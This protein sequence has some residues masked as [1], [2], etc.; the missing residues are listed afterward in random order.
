V[1]CTDYSIPDLTGLL[2]L[3][4]GL[5]YDSFTLNKQGR[6]EM[7]RMEGQFFFSFSLDYGLF[8]SR[9]V[10]KMSIRIVPLIFGLETRILLRF[11]ESYRWHGNECFFP[12]WRYGSDFCRNVGVF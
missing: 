2:A 1:S 9:T 3:F 7:S 8:S 12:F 5:A 4:F 11:H 6:L 10:I